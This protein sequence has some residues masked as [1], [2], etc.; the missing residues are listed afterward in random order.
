MNND[1]YAIHRA[2]ARNATIT[3]EEP[4]DSEDMSKGSVTISKTCSEIILTG[5]EY[6]QKI[7]E[8]RQVPEGVERTSVND[9]ILDYIAVNWAQIDPEPIV[10][11]KPK[12]FPSNEE[13]DQHLEKANNLASTQPEEWEQILNDNPE[14]DNLNRDL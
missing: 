3:F 5:I 9:M 10:P 6:E 8:E 14:L 4:A 1:Q 11:P 13:I 2:I 12:W 7:R